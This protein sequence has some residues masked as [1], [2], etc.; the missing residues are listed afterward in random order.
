MSQITP[1]RKRQIKHMLSTE[2]P[3]IRI[4]KGGTTPEIVKEIENQLKRNKMV[5]VKILKTALVTDETKQIAARTAQQ[6]SSSLIEIRGHTFI[7]YK[8]H[9]K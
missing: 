1:R 6:T 3:T 5:K 2:K 4:G 8:R 7:L 9:A